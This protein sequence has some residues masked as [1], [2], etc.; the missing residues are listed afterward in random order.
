[1][2]PRKSSIISEQ[3][4]NEATQL[5]NNALTVLKPHLIA[6]TSAERQSLPKMSDKTRPFVEKIKYYCETEPQFIPPFMDVEALETDLQNYHN[7]VPLLRLA[8]QLGSGLD[9]TVL[10]TGGD[11]YRNALNYYNSTKL[12]TRTGVPKAKTIHGDLSK[13]FYKNRN[14]E[15][16]ASDETA[17]EE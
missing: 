1:M 13:R 10:K 4:I 12:G 7:L 15:P 16:N 17:Q 2:T 6:L 8:K 5:L 3:V 9:D 14:N 11:C